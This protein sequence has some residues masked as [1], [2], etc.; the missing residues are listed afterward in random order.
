M[1]S[2]L[3]RSDIPIFTHAN[4]GPFFV[5]LITINL[6]KFSP[7]TLSTK[8]KSTSSLERFTIFAAE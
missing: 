5:S 2:T 3:E 7:F 6:L 1:T 8:N 4:C